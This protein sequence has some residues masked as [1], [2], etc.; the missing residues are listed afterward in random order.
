MVSHI[1]MCVEM[2][3]VLTESVA[4]TEM[5]LCD[6]LSLGTTSILDTV[7]HFNSY[8]SVASLMREHKHVFMS[9]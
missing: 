4:S 3:D 6:R 9:E 5:Y 2:H 7:M 1:Q 8:L